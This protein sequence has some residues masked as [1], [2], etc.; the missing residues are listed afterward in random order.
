MLLAVRQAAAAAA[1]PCAMSI[2][3][4]SNESNVHW[5]SV[6]TVNL[7]ILFYWCDHHGW[8]VFYFFSHW[9]IFHAVVGPCTT[10]KGW[11]LI[12]PNMPLMVIN[13]KHVFSIVDASRIYPI[14]YSNAIARAFV[15]HLLFLHSVWHASLDHS[16]LSLF[17][18]QF[19]LHLF[20]FGL[21]LFVHRMCVFISLAYLTFPTLSAKRDD[22]NAAKL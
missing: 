3:T 10:H 13:V 1:K 9:S 8:L 4:E 15:T 6:F 16:S 19:L 18:L 20:L 2:L 21:G 17:L 22:A 5:N 7:R 14:V 11:I 12:V